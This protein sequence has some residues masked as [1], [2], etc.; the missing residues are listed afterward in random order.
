[1]AYSWSTQVVVVTDAGDG[2][3]HYHPTWKLQPLTGSRQIQVMCSRL[4]SP[5]PLVAPIG[6]TCPDCITAMTRSEVHPRPS[7]LRQRL[8]A[9]WT[10]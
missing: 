10:S 3:A 7:W 4:I 8:R 9:M 1:M 2:R 5:A 6:P